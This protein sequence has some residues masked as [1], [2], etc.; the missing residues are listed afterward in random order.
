M[1]IKSPKKSDLKE[2]QVTDESVYLQRRE[3]IKKMGFVGAGTLL[4]SAI[5]GCKNPGSS[6]YII[7]ILSRTSVDSE[8]PFERITICL[9]F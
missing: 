8:S 6:S 5:P 3:L 2:H 4:S 7:F 9:C 1:L